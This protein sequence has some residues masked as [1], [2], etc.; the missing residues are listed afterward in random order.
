MIED[1][2]KTARSIY[3]VALVAGTAF[4]FFSLSIRAPG[5]ESFLALSLVR[6]LTYGANEFA[7]F[8]RERITI[9]E[10]LVPIVRAALESAQSKG[11]PEV[12]LGP[13]A[14]QDLRDPLHLVIPDG[15]VDRI[16]ASASAG[17]ISID[18]SGRLAKMNTRIFI[19]DAKGLAETLEIAALSQAKGPKEA[20]HCVWQT[21]EYDGVHG[22][23]G[24]I[25]SAP[26]VMVLQADPK[27]TPG[28]QSSIAPR[29]PGRV[30]LV[31]HTSILDWLLTRQDTKSAFEPAAAGESALRETVKVAIASVGDLPPAQAAR[32][33]SME[34]VK[35]RQMSGD[36][37]LLGL[38]LPSA[39]ALVALPI[40]WLVTTIQLA[41]HGWHLVGIG[42]QA[43]AD[44]RSFAWSPLVSPSGRATAELVALLFGLPFSAQAVATLHAVSSHPYEMILGW[45]L[46]IPS[47]WFSFSFTT[48]V[49]RL[50]ILAKSG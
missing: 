30:D 16:W 14:E 1:S 23:G 3:W 15:S 19:P 4:L 46:M 43:T 8:R 37:D 24:R 5:M 34:I 9:K 13:G 10:D 48:A 7:E 39:L 26:I 2:L 50:R 36:L 47:A 33:L 22:V 25:D 44:L 27:N 29:V 31:P 40:L 18:L 17:Q 49:R 35:D 20:V 41:N 28:P 21:S 32:Q 6:A 38:K 12:A 45:M 42:R 11:A